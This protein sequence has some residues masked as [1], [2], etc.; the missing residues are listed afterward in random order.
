MPDSLCWSLSEIKNGYNGNAGHN[1][2][3]HKLRLL[4]KQTQTHE[5]DYQ[6]YR[7]A[8]EQAER[9]RGI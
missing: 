1:A 6:A 8:Q 5:A 2:R 3:H 7:L 9:I 4:A